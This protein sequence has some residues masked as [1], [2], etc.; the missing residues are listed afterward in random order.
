MAGRCNG[1]RE[2]V[3][4]SAA[5]CYRDPFSDP[6]NP[7]YW[8]SEADAAQYKGYRT[9]T[10]REMADIPVVEIMNVVVMFMTVLFQIIGSVIQELVSRNLITGIKKSREILYMIRK[11]I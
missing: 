10:A 2:L 7:T 8:K 3:E 5:G 6:A 1:L 4:R 9:G 11:T